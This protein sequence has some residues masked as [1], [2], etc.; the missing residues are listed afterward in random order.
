MRKVWEWYKGGMGARRENIILT[1]KTSLKN[2]GQTCL[3]GS[4]EGHMA[5]ERNVAKG[6]K[7][8]AE[9]KRSQDR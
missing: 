9:R 8:G 5:K 3:P 4:K 7:G 1:V 6:R 2:D